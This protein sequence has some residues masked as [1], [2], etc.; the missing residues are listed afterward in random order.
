MEISRKAPKTREALF[1][2]R[3]LANKLNGRDVKH[4]LEAV[5]RGKEMPQ[6]Q[7]PKLERNP[8]GDVEADGAVE[9]LSSLLEVRAKQHGVAAP[10]IATHSDLSKLVRGHREGLALMEGWRYDIAGC[11]AHRPARG[12]SLVVP[13]RWGNRGRTALDA[14]TSE[15]NGYPRQASHCYDECVP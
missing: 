14:S 3:G 11:G 2:V 13:V 9:L 4:I 6:D 5:A 12:P 8:K 7:W 1:E 10:L 15:R